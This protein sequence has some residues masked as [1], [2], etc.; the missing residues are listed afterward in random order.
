MPV[1]SSKAHRR[2]AAL[3]VASVAILFTAACG[4]S[5]DSSGQNGDGQNGGGG[6]SAFAAYIS[7]LNENG[8]TITMPSGGPGG[9][10]RPS[11]AP[12]GVRPSGEPGAFPS[13]QPRP[14]GSAGPRGGGGFP[15]GG[16]FTKP[17]G[18]DDATWEKAQTACAS[19][20]PSMGAGRGNRNGGGNGADAAY[21]N[22]LKENGVTDTSNLD[23]SDATVQKA[24]ETCKV[25]KPT[26]TATS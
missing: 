22:C 13:G 25:L 6:N 26:A 5:D 11:G 12:D 10:A 9:G 20:R 1:V 15:G 8:V 2:A 4:G 23:T 16:G 3:L 21:T 14:E 17:D 18:V 19:V 24:V 7:C